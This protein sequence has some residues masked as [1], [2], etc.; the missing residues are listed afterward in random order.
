MTD[1]KQR[2]TEL[3]QRREDTDSPEEKDRLTKELAKLNEKLAQ[4]N[5]ISE[6]PIQSKHDKDYLFE[7]GLGII[8]VLSVLAGTGYFVSKK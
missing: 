3:E 1:W 4:E 6:K 5:I 7:I 8:G 2:F